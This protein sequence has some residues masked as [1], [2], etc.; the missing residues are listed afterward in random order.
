MLPWLTLRFAL[1]DTDVAL[2]DIG[3]ALVDIGVAVVDH[4]YCLG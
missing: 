2:V 4:Q 3:V 1:V